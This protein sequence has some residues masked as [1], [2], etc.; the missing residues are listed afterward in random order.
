MVATLVA[1]IQAPPAEAPRKAGLLKKI[2]PA[3]FIV[4][5]LQGLLALCLISAQQLLTPRQMPFGVV[6]PSLVVQ[7]VQSK[8]PLA[9]VS[10]ASKS[11]ALGAIDRGQIYGAFVT[12]R[13]GDTLIVVPAK[14]LLRPGRTGARVPSCC[15]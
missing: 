3:L 14:R 1:S 12:S 8:I 4:L 11:A 6:G 7:G 15:A 2:L 10:Y 9:P 5:V 13:S